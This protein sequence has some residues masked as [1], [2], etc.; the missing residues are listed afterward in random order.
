MFLK[1]S[2]MTGFE[3]RTYG[4][5]SNRSAN[6]PSTGA[7]VSSSLRQSFWLILTEEDHQNFGKF[8]FFNLRPMS[9]DNAHLLNM[10]NHLKPLFHLSLSFQTKCINQLSVGF[11]LVLLENKVCTL[12]NRPSP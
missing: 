5:G 9:L 3:P 7:L 2:P 6:S 1:I 10:L 11:K 12:T 8:S 4:V